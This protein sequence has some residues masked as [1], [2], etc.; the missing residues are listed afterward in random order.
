LLV[1]AFLY[2]VTSEQVEEALHLRIKCLGWMISDL[3]DEERTWLA[4]LFRRKVWDCGYEFVKL[5]SHSLGVHATGRAFEILG[6][7]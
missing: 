2:Q 7:R 1:L 5:V 4:N 3:G 6:T